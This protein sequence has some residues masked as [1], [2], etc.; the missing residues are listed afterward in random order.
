[1][2]KSIIWCR[3]IQAKWQPLSFTAHVDGC[4]GTSPSNSLHGL[5]RDKGENGR[6]IRCPFP[7]PQRLSRHPAHHRPLPVNS[8][9]NL[10]QHFSGGT[11][12][13][14]F[15]YFPVPTY[16]TPSTII[17]PLPRLQE[18]N[19]RPLLRGAAVT[20]LHACSISVSG[21]NSAN[22]PFALLSQRHLK[23][24]TLPACTVNH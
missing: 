5:P 9:C 23:C 21:K 3:G 1:M 14:A 4:G 10:H 22:K 11:F 8:P 18:R 15:F 19:V 12:A 2:L 17:A 20:S 24:S 7:Q 16:G 13:G 6:S